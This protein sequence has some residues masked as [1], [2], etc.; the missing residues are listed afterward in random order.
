MTRESN[1]NKEP[2]ERPFCA[3][4]KIGRNSNVKLK[5]IARFGK[6]DHQIQ[7]R[8]MQDLQNK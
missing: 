2:L 5:I 1:V 4:K 7:R 3:W 8:N 6:Q